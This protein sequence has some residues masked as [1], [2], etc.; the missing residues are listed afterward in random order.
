MKHR[1]AARVVA[2]A[3]AVTVSA[4]ASF[5]PDGGMGEVRTLA[6]ER[7][8]PPADALG[9][10]RDRVD[11]L[12]KQP[13]TADAAVEIAFIN[14]AALQARLADLGIAEAD[15]VQA[16]TLRN[17]VFAYSNKRNAEIVQIER[18]VIV[19]VAALVTMPLALEIEE[20]RLAQAKVAAA[21]DVIATAAMTR[22]AYF[23]AVAAQE[24][25]GYY[26]Q[27]KVAAEAGRDL[28]R[29][30]A[31]AGNWNKLAQMREELFHVDA[32]AQLARAQQ[33]AVSERERLVRMLGLRQP[34]A[35][36]LPARLP[37]LPAAP[38]TLNAAEQTAMDARLDVRLANL[39][40]ESVQRTLALTRSSRFLNVFEAGYVNESETGESRKNGY[41]IAIELPIFDWGSARIARAEAQL[42]QAHAR[43]SETEVAARSQVRE[44][45]ASYRTAYDVAKLYRDEVVPLRKRIVDEST[46]RYNAMTIGVFELL[47]DARDQVASVN[48]A[49]EATRDFWLADTALQLALAGSVGRAIAS[50]SRTTPGATAPRQ[51]H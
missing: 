9:A 37:D 35:F 27:V 1:H 31:E 42:R 32:A 41:E 20:R 2:V 12:L 40:S 11:T 48:A 17:P 44:G 5:S 10:S 21:A 16:G 34:T 8:G 45:Y 30:M 13:L 18:S 51:G 46:L 33:S 49:I 28:A 6:R 25:V 29:R 3:V 14:N 26:A 4:C 15:L 22:E 36:Q 38:M 43:A 24:M 19:N 39:E 7:I 50:P 47:A 23:R